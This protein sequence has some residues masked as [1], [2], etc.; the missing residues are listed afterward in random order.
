MT[1]HNKLEEFWAWTYY[2]LKLLQDPASNGHQQF[3]QS[4]RVLVREMKSNFL[5]SLSLSFFPQLIK[6]L[7]SSRQNKKGE[8]HLKLKDS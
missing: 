2:P 3:V 8:G 4:G 7:L 5:T 6:F 1:V